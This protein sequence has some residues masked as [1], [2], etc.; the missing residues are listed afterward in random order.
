MNAQINR[1]VLKQLNGFEDSK[2]EVEKKVK[3]TVSSWKFKLASV[4]VGVGMAS[5]LIVGAFFTVYQWTEEH[6]LVYKP[7]LT[8]KF[9]IPFKDYDVV[10]A[11]FVT[12]VVEKLPEKTQEQVVKEVKDKER[13]M[14]VERIYQYVRFLESEIGFNTRPDATHVYCQS[15]GKINEIGYFPGGNKKYCFSTEE[16]QFEGFM[17]EYNDRMK[18][19]YTLNEFLCE[20]VSGKKQ[21]MCQRSIDI[22]L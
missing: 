4:F 9:M 6:K 15:I 18:K 22:G 13:S 7:F 12:P 8:Y 2:R 19:G 3:K 17:F 14:L 16:K 1:G 20:W 5:T 21:P 11:R 10:V